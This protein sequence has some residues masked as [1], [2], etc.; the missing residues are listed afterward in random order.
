MKIVIIGG[1]AGG[2]SAAARLRR[3]NEHAEIIMYER[4]SYISYANCGLP[5]F[6]GGKITDKNKLTLQTPESFQ[7][8]FRVD[9]RINQEVIEINRQKR[10]V[11]ARDISS[12]STTEENYDKLILSPGAEP[13]IPTIPGLNDERIFTLRTIPDTYRIHEYIQKH[14]VKSAVVIGGGYIGL[15]MLE[16]L[17]NAG[18][19]VTL[20]QRSQQILRMLDFDMASEVHQYL[21]DIDVNLIL[22]AAINGFSS[23]GES[24]A[25][26]YNDGST[27]KADIVL[28]SIGVRPDS[29]L[30]KDAGLKVNIKGAIEVDPYLRTS[31]E[32]IYAI[33]DAIEVNNFVT[34]EPSHIPLAGPANKQG[35]IVADNIMGANTQF[36]GTQGTSILKLF[37]MTIAATGINEKA[38]TGLNYHYDA[39]HTFSPSHATYYPGAT[40]MS[41]KTLFDKE[42]GRILGAQLIGFTGVDKRCDV[43]A[44]AIRANMTAYDLAE[45]EL[46]YAPP[47]SSAK[48]PVNMIGFAIE[49]IL[50]N[51]VYQQHWADIDNVIEKVQQGQAILLDVRT[52]SEFERGHVDNS[53]H[54]PLDNLRSHINE[55]NSSKEI[56]VYCHSGQR[57]YIACRILMQHGYSCYNI[58]GGYRLYQILSY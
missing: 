42:S 17:K 45:L 3:L 39:I 40:F 16:N 51:K 48:D 12:G 43:L 33:G 4:G 47:F 58:S 56:Y 34:N 2:A 14:N 46:S 57:S 29:Q 1:V 36:K 53:L 6:I 20:M 8:R 18:I 52:P 9:V 32:H 31:D 50:T 19:E 5:Y 44:T 30:A 21:R 25:V 15:E 27:V 49:N 41:I 54:M 35:R 13:V 28:L 23:I 37:D 10:T 26:E 11:I 7:D 22:N 55:L 38:A 24:L